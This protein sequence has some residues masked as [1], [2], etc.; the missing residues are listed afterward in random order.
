MEYSKFLARKLERA[1]PTGFEVGRDQLNPKFFPFQAAIARWGA[2]QGNYL[3]AL[4]VGMGKT[5]LQ[6]SD[7]KLKQAR[8]GGKVMFVAPLAVAHQTIVEAKKLSDM[9]ITY[10]QSQAD[11]DHAKGNFFI[12]NQEH[13]VKGKFDPGS[14]NI[15]VLDEASKFLKAFRGKARNTLTYQ[16]GPI[17]RKTAWTAT[18]APNRLIE[19]LN[20]A[21]F[22]GIKKT[23]DCLTRW[24]IN[25]A[26]KKG[27]DA[28]RLKRHS[29]K[30]F[31]E[32]L[33]SW[34]VVMSKPSDL[35]FSDDGY[36]LPPLHIHYEDCQTDMTRAFDQVTKEGQIRLMPE[37]NLSATNMWADKRATV[38]GHRS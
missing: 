13:I 37:T 38:A 35:G 1:A 23:G 5:I 12:T 7:A 10:V 34:C 20:Y 14:F 16:W 31:W 15:L 25:D 3:G 32:W 26:K 18:P 22:L 11:V 19:L 24:F 30:E 21:E 9:E 36:D 8:Y 6:T 27:V 2:G 17:P 33:A 29:E 28:L 4:A